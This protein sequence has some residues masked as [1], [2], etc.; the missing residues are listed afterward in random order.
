M[1]F[2]FGYEFPLIEVMLILGFLLISSITLLVFVLAKLWAMNKKLDSVLADERKVKRGLEKAIADENIQ[3]SKIGEE[4]KLLE[5][6]NKNENAQLKYIKDVV[7]AI[8]LSKAGKISLEH[9]KEIARQMKRLE[10]LN[11]RENIQ[12]EYI[13]KIVRDINSLK[14]Q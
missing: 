8:T 13:K 2:I 3:L 10:K 14:K 5:R 12:L 1:V 7:N 11:N 4:M 6:V 9:V